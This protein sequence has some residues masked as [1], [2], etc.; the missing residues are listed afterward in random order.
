[1]KKRVPMAVRYTLLIGSLWLLSRCATRTGEQSGSGHA[2]QDTGSF[3][4]RMSWGAAPVR[5]SDSAGVWTLGGEQAAVTFRAADLSIDIRED[6]THWKMVPL[7]DGD[8]VVRKKGKPETY[9]LRLSDA[10][11]REVVYYDAG[12]KTGI[13]VTLGDFKDQDL[14]LYLTLAVEAY[15]G[16]ILCSV[17]AQENETQV[18]QL[19]WPG[20]LDPRGV[21]YTVLPSFWGILLPSDWPKPFN[22]IRPSDS[23]GRIP[24]TDHSEL[25]SNVIEDW[26]MSWW[27]FEKGNTA[28]MII[29]ETPDDA[30]YQFSHP[31]GGPT[32]IGP[33]WRAS[34]G[35]L[36]YQRRLRICLLPG[37]NYVTMAK[38]YR[39]YVRNTGLFVSLK[40][41]TERNPVV[42]KLIGAPLM[43]TSILVHY[44]EGSYRWRRDSLTRHRL[45]SFEACGDMLQKQKAAGLDRLTVILTGWGRYGYDRQHPDIMPP[46]PEA[47]GPQK[48]K[49]LIETAH[50]LG[51]LIGF[52]DQYRDYY[53]DAPSYDPQFAIHE[54][55]A[56]GKPRAFPGSRFG[57]FKE[58]R[59]PFMDHW[60]GGKQTYLSGPFKLGH[61]QQNYRW[62]SGHGVRVD[63]S[64]LD[65]F[66]YVP[67]DEDFNPEHPVTRTDD[68]RYRAAC[69]N[70]VRNNVGFV[71]TEAGCDW[72][73]PYTDFSSPEHSDAGIPVP[74]MQ[75]VYHDAVL[76]PYSPTDLRGFL[77]GGLPQIRASDL[78]RDSTRKL[79]SRMAKLNKRLA[80]TELLNDEF[81]DTDHRIERTTFSD[82]TT[83]T[84]DWDYHTV[85]ISPE[86]K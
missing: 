85:R 27:G 2:S 20:P 65:V 6:S 52:H 58:G 3:Q 30:A 29:V 19:Q 72:T 39:A 75:L 41:K 64:Y 57:D 21:D 32:L 60:D 54:A 68:I 74:L 28:M 37:G 80:F 12:Y 55:F 40:E 73:I 49:A 5:V 67:P 79:I 24:Q 61:L 77:Y 8:L 1:M 76:V 11:R 26:S 13:K 43:R 22:P 25:Q 46:A 70:W 4:E 38:R 71:G 56:D 7:G 53:T 59:I 14:T 36:A 10:R 9:P 15:T 84:V 51:Y 50:S 42:E 78:E 86:L 18:E 33:R 23:T 82:G 66:G 44:K 69:Y 83:V 35:K 63:G 47:G 81:L 62:L 31:A 16:D 17:T 34:L 48:L 45:T